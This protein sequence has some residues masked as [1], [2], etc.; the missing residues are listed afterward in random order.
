MKPYACDRF[1]EDLLERYSLGIAKVEECEPLEEHLL[2][3]SKCQDRLHVIDGYVSIVRAAASHLRLRDE[4]DRLPRK[5]RISRT[6][7]CSGPSSTILG[8]PS[9][10]APSRC[11]RAALP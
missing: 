8:P 1:S 2:L 9:S 10:R 6:S 3:C 5:P 7:R 11:V 4:P